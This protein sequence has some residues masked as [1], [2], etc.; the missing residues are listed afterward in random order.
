MRYEFDLKK[1]IF[2]LSSEREPSGKEHAKTNRFLAF[3]ETFRQSL[4][5]NQQKDYEKLQKLQDD[6]EIEK[7]K[8]LIGWIVDFLK[9]VNI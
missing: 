2:E 3:E 8:T 1:I 7:E 6:Y 4:T 9:E 5:E